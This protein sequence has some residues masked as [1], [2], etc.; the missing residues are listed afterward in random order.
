MHSAG[1]PLTWNRAPPEQ[2]CSETGLPGVW[3]GADGHIWSVRAVRA[4][5]ELRL[6]SP[7]LSFPGGQVEAHGH[8]PTLRQTRL[9]PESPDALLLN[10]HTFTCPHGTLNKDRG[11]RMKTTNLHDPDIYYHSSFHILWP[12]YIN[13]FQNIHSVN[14]LYTNLCLWFDEVRVKTN[15]K[16]CLLI[17]YFP[18]KAWI[19]M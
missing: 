11:P 3:S 2:L 5:R 9:E 13:F 16:F 7:S 15:L 1:S 4:G 14:G 18:Q 8:P 19:F 12:L 17:H 10:I 6:G